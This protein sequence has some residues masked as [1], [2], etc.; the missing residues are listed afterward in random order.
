MATLDQ[1]LS[2]PPRARTPEERRK[3]FR[4]STG[5]PIR[6][7]SSSGKHIS[8]TERHGLLILKTNVGTIERE[9]ELEALRTFARRPISPSDLDENSYRNGTVLSRHGTRDTEETTTLSKSPKTRRLSRTTALEQ[10]EV[11]RAID[12]KDL[13]LLGEFRDKAFHLLLERQAGGQTP[14][15]YAMQH[16][17][18]YQEVVLFLVGAVSQW[19]NRLN[20]SDFSKPETAK[21]LKL[22]RA[23]LKVAIDEGLTKLQTGLIA[24]FL[25]TLVMCEGDGWIR[26]QLTPISFALRAGAAGKAVEVAG[27]TVRR[28]C[29]TSLKNADLIA[30]VED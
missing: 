18:S 17:P 13:D 2:P 15:V 11:F 14:M 21:L 3:E 27:S 25:Q 1:N 28:F 16:G 22:S 24:S 10:Y 5:Q 29:T 23:N 12:K 30:D 7:L 20:D 8:L 6:R 4:R 26:D 19:I 9:A